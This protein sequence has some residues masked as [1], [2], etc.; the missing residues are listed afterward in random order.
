MNKTQSATRMMYSNGKGVITKRVFQSRHS[1]TLVRKRD[2]QVQKEAKA[3]DFA[4]ASSTEEGEGEGKP[5]TTD[6]EAQVQAQVQVQKDWALWTGD[7]G[8]QD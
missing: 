7:W 8:L 1:F 6:T 5:R 2:L 4:K 3:V